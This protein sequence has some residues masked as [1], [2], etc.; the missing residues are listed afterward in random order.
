[1]PT[2]LPTRVLRA[3]DVL[4]YLE[5]NDD[6]REAAEKRSGR[7]DQHDFATS[8]QAALGVASGAYYRHHYDQAS[9]NTGVGTPGAYSRPTTTSGQQIPSTAE[10]TPVPTMTRTVSTGTAVLK[11]DARLQWIW[12]INSAGVWSGISNTGPSLVQFCIAV[13]GRVLDWTITGENDPTRKAPWALKPQSPQRVYGTTM[14]PGSHQ[15]RSELCAALGRD[16]GSE[17]LGTLYPVEPGTHTVEVYCRRIKTLDVAIILSTGYFSPADGGIYIY[18]RQMFTQVLPLIPASAQAFDGVE[19]ASLA[20]GVTFNAAAIQTA[21]VDALRNSYNA[22][23]A[24]GLAR[25]AFN[26]FHLPST[27]RDW[28]QATIVP[29]GTPFTDDFYPGFN[30]DTLAGAST[31]ATGWWLTNDGAGNNLRTDQTHPAAFSGTSASTFLVLANIHM[32]YLDIPAG[33]TGSPGQRHIFG[34]FSIGYRAGGVNDVIVESEALVNNWNEWGRGV[35]GGAAAVERLNEEEDV[36]LMA[37][38][39][40]PAGAADIDYFGVYASAFDDNNER[41]VL[42]WGRGCISV[43][44]FRD[45]VT[46]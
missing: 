17:R 32:R 21:R 29:A 4:D 39:S 19:I 36:G 25:G 33:G 2:I 3:A 24:G 5:L 45:E 23:A 41:G 43:I 27:I 22:I 13:D 12:Q 40:R 15:S 30:S 6:Y 16:M 26:H 10:W 1:M 20:P 8:L 18:N 46:P 31:G 38:V 9:A 37:V 35:S 42:G 44:Q 14:L 7:L 28:A 11:I 34:A